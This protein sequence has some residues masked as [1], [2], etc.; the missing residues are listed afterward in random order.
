MI[1]AAFHTGET[2]RC[3]HRI[4]AVI[5]F[6]Q[7]CSWPGSHAREKES[8]YE[9]LFRLEKPQKSEENIRPQTENPLAI[10]GAH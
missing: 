9:S 7:I 8:F 4:R 5:F 10:A 2:Y 6:R 1:Q 3:R